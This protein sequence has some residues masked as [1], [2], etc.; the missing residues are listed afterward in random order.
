MSLQSDEIKTAKYFLRIELEYQR[1]IEKLFIEALNSIRAE[2]SKIYERY[3]VKGILTKAEM[4]RYNR[5]TALESNLSATMGDAAKKSI[6][7]IN[8]LRPEQYGA[9]FFR[10]AWAID[11]ATGVAISWGVLDK[12]AVIAAMANPAYKLATESLLSGAEGTIRIAIERGLTLGKSYA[13]MLKEIKDTV[14]LE[15]WKALRIMRTEL[16]TAQ[17]LGTIYGYEQALAN[18]VPGRIIWNA[19]LDSKTRESHQRMDGVA[20]GEDGYFR[21]S[22]TARY[23]GDPELSAGERINCR[24]RT[25]FELGGEGDY[26]PILRRSRE[27]GVIPYQTYGEWEKGRKLFG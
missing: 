23:P 16:H 10:S 22:I 1:E 13:T 11:N 25:R 6:G 17:E 19:T 8:R 20:R 4:T 27:D 14:N 5:L 9:G 12:A 3:A 26:G 15:A 18:G 7:I 21:G 2:M 24:C